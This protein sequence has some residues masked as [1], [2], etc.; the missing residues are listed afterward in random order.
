M[1]TEIQTW[2]I[3]DGKLTPVSNSLIENGRRER[4]HLEE[5]I[6]S[7]PQILGTDI[8]IFGEQ[9]QT[10]SGPLDFIGIDAYGNIVIIELKRDKLP[11]EVLAQ[12]IDYASDIASYSTDQLN[13]ICLKYTEK[14]I[15]DFL[16]ESFPDTNWEEVGINQEQ[17]LL[18]VG[19]AIDEPLHRMI[20]WLSEKYSVPINAIVLHYAKTRSGDELLSR[21]VIIPEEVEQEKAN[22]KK[23]VIERSDEPGSYDQLLLKDKLK[24]YLRSDKSSAQRIRN[25][26]LP[27][28]LDNDVVTRHEMKAEF[29]ARGAARDEKEAGFFLSAISNQLGH[30][31]NDYLRQVIAYGAPVNTWEKD[32]FTLR[33]EYKQLVA[34]V[35]AELRQ[36]GE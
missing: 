30:K 2:Q 25:Y 29:I 14:T 4:E 24:Q 5:W 11:R 8:S 35:L 21:T 10:K 6:K 16:A 19:F 7:N 18:L 9:V 26:F 15:G 1:A 33:P 20:E 27:A 36:P 34:E 32:N 22:K 31:R 17:R 13:E 3:V 28:L 12:A 23:F